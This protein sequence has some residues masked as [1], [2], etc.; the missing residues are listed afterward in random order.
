[1]KEVFSAVWAWLRTAYGV[2]TVVLSM[3]VVKTIAKIVIGLAICSSMI[4]GDGIHNVSDIVTAVF[5][6]I[7][8][9]ISRLPEDAEYPFG[10]RSI[11]SVLS[12]LVG[13]VL[14]AAAFGVFIEALVGLL[15]QVPAWDAKLR[16]AMGGLPGF[17]QLPVHHPLTLT[18]TLLPWV[19]G[20]TGVS[21]VLSFLVSR[22]QISVGRSTGQESIVAD[23]KETK[24][25]GILEAGTLLGIVLVRL[26]DRPWIEQ[27]CS[28]GVVFLMGQTAYEIVSRGWGGLMQRSIGLE[29]DCRLKEIC[30]ETPGVSGVAE[31][32]TFRV[33]S[34][35]IVN[36]KLF[37]ALTTEGCRSLKHGLVAKLVEYL[38][39]QDFNEAKFHVRF[40]PPEVDSR[41]TAYTLRAMTDGR[42]QITS[43]WKMSHVAL[44]SSECGIQRVRIVQCRAFD[45]LS[46]LR[47][48]NVCELVFDAESDAA[49]MV[50]LV[51]SGMRGTRALTTALEDYDIFVPCR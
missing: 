3:Y 51:H 5:V 13:V 14:G 32:K 17:M 42:F 12:V 11:E 10:R 44:V 19:I 41:P 33:G 34:M 1:M 50:E 46:F 24:S 15:S 31:L 21:A 35:A 47:D 40:D 20:I 27:I 18:P 48:R 38:K 8:V 36:I 22:Y 4:T 30:L 28:L 9:W 26:T 2:M 43:R 37:S 6:I 25:D 29:H 45:L 23:G 39:S 49:F 16:A 7:T